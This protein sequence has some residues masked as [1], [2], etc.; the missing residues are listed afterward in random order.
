MSK[1]TKNTNSE[2]S[3]GDGGSNGKPQNYILKNN[4]FFTEF[5]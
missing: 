3:W 4:L 5:N 1:A 2:F